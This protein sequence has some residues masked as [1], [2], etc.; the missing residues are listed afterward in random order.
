MSWIF[1]CMNRN[2]RSELPRPH[3]W[4]DTLLVSSR[5]FSI[6]VAE[7]ESVLEAHGLSELDDADE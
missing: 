4:L 6:R 3:S 1:G 5:L 7:L 2:E